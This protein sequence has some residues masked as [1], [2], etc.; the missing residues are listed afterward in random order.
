ML[1]AEQPRATSR[2]LVEAASKQDDAALRE[3]FR[4]TS[5]GSGIEVSFEREPSYFGALGIQ[6]NRSEVGII[7][8]RH[9]GRIVG[10]GTRIMRKG[11]LNGEATEIGYLGDLRI[12]PE[13]RNRT[14]TARIYRALQERGPWCDWYYTVIFE[15]N[16]HALETVAKARAGLPTYHDCGRLLCPGIELRGLLPRLS[17]PGVSVR[18]GREGDFPQIVDCLNRNLTR[19]QFANFHSLADFQGET[20]WS[21]LNPVNFHIAEKDNKIVG[22]IAGWDQSAFKQ[23]RIVRYHGHWRWLA[24]L[25]RAV[26]PLRRAPGLPRPPGRNVIEEIMVVLLQWHRRRVVVD[27]LVLGRSAPQP[28][29]VGLGPGFVHKDQPSAVPIALG[30]LPPFTPGLDVVALL[31][32]G[33]QR[34]FYRSGSSPAEHSKWREACIGAPGPRASPPACCRVDAQ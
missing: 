19:R 26:A 6:G 14:L 3:L 16:V 9:S 1:T 31:F 21:G 27:P 4:R 33:V 23:T 13:F 2:F 28:R 29:H 7:R 22:V 25:S 24:P 15:E 30:R 8:D 12:D 20:R 18:I 34:F 17:V 10:S 32:A 11:F 5:M